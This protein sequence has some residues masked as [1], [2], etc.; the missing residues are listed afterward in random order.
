MPVGRAREVGTERE[1]RR[2]WD[3]I[4]STVSGR[5]FD[6]EY[7]ARKEQDCRQCNRSRFKRSTNYAPKLLE[8]RDAV[9]RPKPPSGFLRLLNVVCRFLRR[10]FSPASADQRK[11][12][13]AEKK[14]SRAF[15]ET[16][17]ISSVRCQV[18]RKGEA[19]PSDC[20]FRIP[21][22]EVFFPVSYCVVTLV[23][24]GLRPL[25]RE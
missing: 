23:A 11:T 7:S 18:F 15:R 24:L 2:A 6:R 10:L 16:L 1:D 19:G 14:A 5:S 3:S 22:H 9:S 8:I 21:A 25:S 12:N 17:P 20:E 4:C 13:F